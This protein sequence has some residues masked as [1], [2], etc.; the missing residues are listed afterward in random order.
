MKEH[1]IQMV[2]IAVYSHRHAASRKLEANQVTVP[3]KA[4]PN[5]CFIKA[6]IDTT[7]EILVV[8]F[9]SSLQENIKANLL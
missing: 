2:V 5:V 8:L 9:Y 7:Q 4:Y 3:V 1:P 6:R